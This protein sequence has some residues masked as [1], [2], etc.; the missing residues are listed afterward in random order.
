[1]HTLYVDIER[2]HCKK[3]NQTYQVY[4]ISTHHQQT[5]CTYFASGETI[6]RLRSLKKRKGSA[7]YIDAWFQISVDRE[8]NGQHV[9]LFTREQLEKKS[10]PVLRDCGLNLQVAAVADCGVLIEPAFRGL[11][12][13][14]FHSAMTFHFRIQR[15]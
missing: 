11:P 15:C 8:V 14:Q 1:M 10:Q 13:N 3:C 2:K 9:I 4:I 12:L 7:V 5:P 6:L